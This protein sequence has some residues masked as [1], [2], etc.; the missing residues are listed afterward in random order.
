[1]ITDLE[2]RVQ[3]T[4]LK[5]EVTRLE[6]LLQ[7][8]RQTQTNAL[9]AK[10]L[11]LADLKVSVEMMNQELAKQTLAAKEMKDEVSM[12]QHQLKETN[13]QLEAAT[14]SYT[15]LFVCCC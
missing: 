14:V 3:D 15:F 6:E 13:S 11:E 9:E 8:E 1:M 4:V 12:L 5:S 2:A 7:E 10:D